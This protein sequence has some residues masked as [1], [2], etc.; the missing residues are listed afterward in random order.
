[1]TTECMSNPGT[2]YYEDLCLKDHGRTVTPAGHIRVIDL[3]NIQLRDADSHAN[4]F[5]CQ[6]FI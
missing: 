3:F 2:S 4:E 5:W 1:M 6:V